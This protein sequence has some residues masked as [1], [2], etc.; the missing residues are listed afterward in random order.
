MKRFQQMHW[1]KI[2]KKALQ[3]FEDHLVVMLHGVEDSFP[4][5]L[6]DRLLPQV[7]RSLS[8][9]RQTNIH[10]YL[11]TYT[12]LYRSHDYNQTPY[13]LVG[14]TLQMNAK[15]G[16]RNSWVPHSMDGY[17]TWILPMLHHI[18]NKSRR[19]TYSQHMY[20]T[21]PRVTWK[22]RIM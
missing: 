18:Q 15:L 13:A 17:N 19:S 3:T 7:E 8:L 9:L 22:D 4:L 11:M 14:C 2:S 1:R 20:I 5:H 16:K 21:L 6:W 10:K 12:N